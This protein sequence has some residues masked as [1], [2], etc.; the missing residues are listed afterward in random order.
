[1]KVVRFVSSF[2][3]LAPTCESKGEG[4]LPVSLAPIYVGEGEGDGADA[5]KGMSKGEGEA[6]YL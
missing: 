1:M 4:V 3:E 6:V 2:S 5:S